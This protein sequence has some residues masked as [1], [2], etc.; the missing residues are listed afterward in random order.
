[1][2]KS[3]HIGCVYNYEHLAR[4]S[5]LTYASNSDNIFLA[6]NNMNKSMPLHEI[7]NK[8]IL[9]QNKEKL[10]CT[11][12][13]IK[14]NIQEIVMNKEKMLEVEISKNNDNYFL[15]AFEGGEVSD[16]TGKIYPV[17]KL[18]LHK[19]KNDEDCEI[20]LILHKNDIKKLSKDIQKFIDIFEKRNIAIN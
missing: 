13:P 3:H 18:F 4:T 11:L 1:M 5:N 6:K 9:S 2:K 20:K 7:I 16:K 12:N 15:K 8:L 19:I 14:K 17:I 10:A